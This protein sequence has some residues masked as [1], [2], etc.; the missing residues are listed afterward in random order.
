M[1]MPYNE[2]EDMSSHPAPQIFY[3]MGCT[4]AGSQQHTTVNT[5]YSERSS[6]KNT[7]I[8]MLASVHGASG[9]TQHSQGAL[10]SCC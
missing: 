7:V 9:G 2:S 3:S 10:S 4:T 8:N 5:R 6:L 1:H